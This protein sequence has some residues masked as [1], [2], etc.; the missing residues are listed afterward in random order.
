MENECPFQTERLKAFSYDNFTKSQ[1]G[2]RSLASRIIHIMTPKVTEALPAGWQ[3]LHTDT[4]ANN[5]IN[6]VS[7]ESNLLL[8]QLKKTKEIVG[9][10]FLYEPAS[11]KTPIDVR[12]GYLLNEDTWGHGLASELIEGLLKWCR[13]TGRIRTITGGVEPDN[14]ASIKVLKK[15]GFIQTGSNNDGTLFYV[16]DF[17]QQ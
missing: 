12:L 3:N 13:S 17:C 15:N 1:I 14:V 2:D 4:D 7:K 11:L 16:Y 8:V 5:W 9:F 10:V 6:D